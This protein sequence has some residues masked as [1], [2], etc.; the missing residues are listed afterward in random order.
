MKTAVLGTGNMGSA[1]IRGM[2][3]ALGDTVDIRAWDA[4][5]EA[6]DGL[7]ARVRRAAPG[8]WFG[9]GADPDVVLVAVKPADVAAALQGFKDATPADVLWVSIAAGVRIAVYE[10]A[11]GAGARVCR[12]M[13][14]TPAMVGKGA[15]GFALNKSCTARDE[16]TVRSILE[17]VGMAVRVDEKLLNAVTGL[18][19]SGP[20]YVYLF[21]EALVE[22]GVAAGL[23]YQSARDLAV[24]TVAG[25]A[26]MV[27]QTGETP[28]SLK[29]AVMSPGGTTVRGLMALEKS[30]MKFGVIQ[31]VVDAARRA[32][33][34]GS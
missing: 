16:H 27:A 33:E 20:A 25:A 19:G 7:P 5:P 32:E 1:L 21:I 17:S 29:A 18:S 23:P 2:D 3:A 34:L 22:G 6:M 15:S 9:G 11:L 12:V 31:A 24:Q 14:N 28:A 26:A 4:R 10:E 13:P 30:G 8:T